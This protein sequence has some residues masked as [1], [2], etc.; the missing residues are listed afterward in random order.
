MLGLRPVRRQGHPRRGRPAHRSRHDLL[1]LPI[2][3]GERVDDEKAAQAVKALYATGFFRDVRLE[4]QGDVLVVSV[5]E[6][7]TI[8]SLTFVGNKEFDTDTVKKALKDI[9]IAEARIFDRSA[10]ERAEQELKRQ[11]ITRGLYAAKVQTTVTP[12]ERNRVAVN[13]TIDEGETAQHRADQHR[14]DQGLHRARSC[15]PRCSSPRPAGSPGTRRT[16]STRSRSSPPTSRRCAAS[17]R[18]AATS[19]SR[20]S[21]RRSRSRPTRKTSTIT[22]NITEGPRYT[23]SDHRLAGEL[24][25][26]EPELR[27]LLAIKPGDTFSR[28]SCR[29]RRRRFSDRLGA[30][31]Y[32][33][34]NVNAVP[35]IDREK[36]QGRVHVLRRPGP[37]GV[38]AQDQHQRQP[39]DPR[40]GDPARDA[41]ARGRVVR[42][43][44]HRA[45][46]GAGAAAGLLRG[47]VNI[48]TPPV[49]GSTDQVDI[50]ITVAEKTTGNLLAGVGYSSAD[51][52]VFS[53]SVSQ[54]NIFGSGNA[55]SL[56]RQHEPV[57]PHDLARLHRAVLDGR[58]RLAH[59]RALRART[60]TRRAQ[61]CRSTP[62]PRRRR[63]RL[64]R[65][66]DRDRH[67]Q[68]RLPRSSTRDLTLY[69]DSPLVY[70]QYVRD[71]GNPTY[72]F[73]VIGGLVARHPRRHPL[74]DA[75]PPAER[76]LE[77][78]LPFGDLAV[79]QGCSTCTS[80]S[81][82]S[83]ATSC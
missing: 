44:A 40:R 33:F 50:E 18:T 66:G 83:T 72:S 67:D 53:A 26:S 14:R 54:Q 39:E 58:R 29:H 80:R 30:E 78:G 31:G 9:G 61:R 81:G 70:Y 32:A 43:H 75:R 36:Q 27:A 45:L 7:P 13:F 10:L 59:D 68:L 74:S 37:A 17:T 1:Y 56:S 28:S 49:P 64:R 22:I 11:Y 42:R 12:Q 23:V 52:L 19:S 57:Q 65:A 46:E 21:R 62:R 73:I 51:G 77:V 20:S 82:R 2:K 6:R 71:F 8:S 60:S 48:E 5:Q 35:E 38:R 79:L 16:T 69:D 15:S 63:D 3:V 4:A 76:L 34:A 41:A 24:M 25:V 55:L 47:H